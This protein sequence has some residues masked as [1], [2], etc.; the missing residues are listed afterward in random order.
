M[1]GCCK[2][3][4]DHVVKSSRQELTLHNALS[5]PL[6]GT[7]MAADKVDRVTLESMLTQMARQISPSLLPKNLSKTGTGCACA[8]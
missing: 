8:A 6:I 5:D 3:T 4:K 2:T 7:L 1:Q